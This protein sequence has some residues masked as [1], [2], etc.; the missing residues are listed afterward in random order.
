MATGLYKNL[1]K[2]FSDFT[3]RVSPNQKS[4]PDKQQPTAEYTVVT[5]PDYQATLS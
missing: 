3:F 5:L 4:R 1:L 2:L